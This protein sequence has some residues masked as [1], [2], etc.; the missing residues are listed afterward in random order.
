MVVII[1]CLCREFTLWWCIAWLSA[2]ATGFAQRNR[3]PCVVQCMCL[4]TD[5]LFCLQQVQIHVRQLC[6]TLQTFFMEN[7]DE[8]FVVESGLKRVASV[9]VTALIATR[10]RAGGG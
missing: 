5:F 2:I 1:G 7:D 4:C 3:I 6:C 8:F 9:V 10:S